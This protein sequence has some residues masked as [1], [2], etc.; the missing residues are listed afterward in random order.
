[1]YTHIYI[2]IYI[3]RER[4]THSDLSTDFVKLTVIR[5]FLSAPGLS[6]VKVLDPDS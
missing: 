2:Y 5:A 1:M 3:Y 4:E 6:Q